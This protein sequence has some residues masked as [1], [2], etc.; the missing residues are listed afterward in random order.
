MEFVAQP[1]RSPDLN[2]L[3]LGAWYSLQSVV[4][5]IK[6]E[7]K[8]TKKITHRIIDAVNKAWDDWCAADKLSGLFNTL[9]HNTHAIV[10]AEGGAEY[11]RHNGARKSR[12]RLE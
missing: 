8:P 5:E 6:Y 10:K 4:E 12:R 1:A 7:V 2:V 9:R 3:D 11:E